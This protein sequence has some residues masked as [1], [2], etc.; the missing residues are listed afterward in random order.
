MISRWNV[1]RIPEIA[2]HIINELSPDQYIT[3]IAEE[4]VEMENFADKPTPA[5]EEY[6]QAIDFLMSVVRAGLKKHQWRGLSKTTEMFRLSYY[7]YVKGLYLKRYDGMVSYAGFAS[8][9][10]MPVGDVWEC[11]VY[12]SPMGN[13]RD[14]DYDFKRLWVSGQARK[15]RQQVRR[16]HSCPLANESYTNMLLNPRYMFK[17]ARGML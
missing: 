10:I 7:Q 3:E 5:G 4:R 2:T 17:V 9:Q 14:F 1:A 13:L 6:A 15:V 16:G 11:A 12:G 8:C